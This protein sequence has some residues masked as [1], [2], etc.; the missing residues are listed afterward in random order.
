MQDDA[1]RMQC[2]ELRDEVADYIIGYWQSVQQGHPYLA[3][4]H[5]GRSTRDMAFVYMVERLNDWSEEL[6]DEHPEYAALLIRQSP[7]GPGDACAH[8]GGIADQ[9]YDA[10]VAMFDQLW[11]ETDSDTNW[12]DQPDQSDQSPSAGRA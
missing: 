11:P 5:P 9:V 8:R 10:Y 4:D 2:T 6:A 12:S 3:C 7:G 1:R